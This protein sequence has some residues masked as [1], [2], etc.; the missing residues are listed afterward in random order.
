MFFL[1][2]PMTAVFLMPVATGMKTEN[3]SVLRLISMP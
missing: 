3:G 1:S 2:F